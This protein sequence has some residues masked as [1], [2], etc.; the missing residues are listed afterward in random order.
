VGREEKE[1]GLNAGVQLNSAS[2]H[3]L[4]GVLR[5]A[6]PGAA[7]AIVNSPRFWRCQDSFS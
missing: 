1:G 4:Y 6:A 7:L 3:S 5:A 2:Q